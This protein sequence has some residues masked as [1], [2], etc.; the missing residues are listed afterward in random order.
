MCKSEDY[1]VTVTVPIYNSSEFI[2]ECFKCL[3][4]QTY[5]NYEVVFVVDERT[6]DNSEEKLMKI[7]TQFDNIRVIKQTDGKGLGG[8]RNIGI[9][10]SK[11]DVIWFL[12][13]DDYPHPLFLEELLKI[14]S[15]TDADTVICNHYQSFEK[16]I[17]DIPNKKYSF[18]VVDGGWATEHY[19]E[20][21]V[22]SWSR[23]QKKSIFNEDTMF[24]E[25]PA[26][27]DIE[28][29]IR[30]LIGSRK[31]CYYNKPL[32]TYVKGKR[33]STKNNRSKELQ[34]LELT[35]L[36][37][38]PYVK[39]K[40]PINIYQNFEKTF[41]L[42]MV[43]QATFSDYRSYSRWYKTSSCRSLIE[44]VQNR[45]FEMK[46]FL[47]SKTLYYFFLYPFSHYFWDRKNGL[48]QD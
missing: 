24:R 42:N 8:A 12:D 15:E 46:L 32:F 31:V 26:A 21:P 29:T 48:W 45:T 36:S 7:A 25:R 35:T 38:I 47:F 41:L 33:T 30:Q 14:M 39:E 23:I 4:K 43:R 9:M 2:D 40:V 17:M 20:Y 1:L 34:S 28:Q 5:E 18:K 16:K 44:K 13:V 6:T 11:G 37:I 19:T 3:L 10:E 22:Y 27:E